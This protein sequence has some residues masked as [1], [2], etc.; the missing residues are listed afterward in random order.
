MKPKR[1][2]VR[3]PT[4]QDK[5]AANWVQAGGSDPELNQPNAQTSKHLSAEPLAKSKDP[6]FVRTTVYLPKPLHKRLKGAAVEAE[7]EM[8]DI[9][10]QAINDWMAKHSDG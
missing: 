5:A 1:G 7:I 3:K 9:A 4:E 6:N 10:E 2:I 8:S